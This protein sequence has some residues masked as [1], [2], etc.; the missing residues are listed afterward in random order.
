MRE[1]V[2][3]QGVTLSILLNC[4]AD[5]GLGGVAGEGK[6]QRQSQQAGSVVQ[7]L[8]A[9]WKH[10]S[11]LLLDVLA[12]WYSKEKIGCELSILNAVL[13]LTKECYLV[14]VQVPTSEAHACEAKKLESIERPI[15]V[16]IHPPPMPLTSEHS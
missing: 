5:G 6:E 9:D 16:P 15:S 7:A 12:S 13:R 14:L 8:A 11:V 1:G 2:Q 10:P 4:T 3:V